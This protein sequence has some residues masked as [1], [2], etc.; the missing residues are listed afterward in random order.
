MPWE[1]SELWVARVSLT[2]S[3]NVNVEQVVEK[4]SARKIAGK[5]AGVESVSQAR[6]AVDEDKLVFLC[7]RTGFY[8]L[9]S[10]SEGEEVGLLLSEPTGADVGGTSSCSSRHLLLAD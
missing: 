5:K 9:Y 1:G 6:W 8:E 3:G 4:G 10:W 7:D 2:A